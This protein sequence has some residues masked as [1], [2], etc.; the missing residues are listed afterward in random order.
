MEVS[1][2]LYLVSPRQSYKERVIFVAG[3]SFAK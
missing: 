2:K 1:S 3:F